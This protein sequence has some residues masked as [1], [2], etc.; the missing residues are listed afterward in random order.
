MTHWKDALCLL[1]I[2]VAYGLAGH[3]DYQDALA[4]EE[5]LRAD[6][7]Q[8]CSAPDLAPAGPAPSLATDAMPMRL[9]AAAPVSTPACG[10][11]HE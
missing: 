2:F 9:A 1:T 3:L 10:P 7:P 8:P 6:M 5:A 11:N 4:M